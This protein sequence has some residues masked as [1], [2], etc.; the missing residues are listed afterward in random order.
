MAEPNLPY[1]EASKLSDG[2]Y[3]SPTQVWKVGASSKAYFVSSFVEIVAVP[4]LQEIYSKLPVEDL[5]YDNLLEN[6]HAST[7]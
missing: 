3:S 5:A 1:D 2:S 7:V 6:L 4:K